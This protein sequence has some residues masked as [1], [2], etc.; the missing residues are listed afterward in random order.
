MNTEE[1]TIQVTGPRNN[2][3]K[4]AFESI[5]KNTAG[6]RFQTHMKTDPGKHIGQEEQ[7]V[8]A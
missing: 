8:T 6:S 1:L 3:Q 5:W 4:L 2:K 7:I